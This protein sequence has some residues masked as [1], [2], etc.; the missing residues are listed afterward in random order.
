MS[1]HFFYFFFLNFVF[2]IY[3]VSPLSASLL[4]RLSLHLSRK[5]KWSL[6]NRLHCLNY[7]S[8]E[9]L[10]LF[11]S[12]NHSRSPPS[13]GFPSLHTLLMFFTLPL[14]IIFESLDLTLN[15]KLLHFH[16]CQSRTLT[17][18]I[19]LAM[20]KETYSF[21]ISP[22][23]LLK[24]LPSIQKQVGYSSPSTQRPKLSVSSITLGQSRCLLSC[25]H[26]TSGQLTAC[27][28]HAT[29]L[30]KASTHDSLKQN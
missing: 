16:L 24:R 15:H 12:S 5:F 28:L 4:A 26:D 9:P 30:P 2:P 13:L 21:Y 20:L 25:G 14:I 18:G 17:S 27:P 10:P 7:T 3:V 8:E 22:V 29:I 23:T 11:L 19:N 1:T 6:A